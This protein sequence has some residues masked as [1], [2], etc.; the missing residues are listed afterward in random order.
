MAEPFSKV[1]LFSGT[2]NFNNSAFEVKTKFYLFLI[3]ANRYLLNIYTAFETI[4]QKK[5]SDKFFF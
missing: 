2:P 4:K 5:V 3:Q 1:Q